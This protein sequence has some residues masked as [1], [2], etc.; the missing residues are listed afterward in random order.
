MAARRPDRL[1]VRPWTPGDARRVAAWLYGGLWRVYDLP[2]TELPGATGDYLA[3]AGAA[4]DRNR[5]RGPG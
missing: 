2:G 1:D 5:P 4:D 3:V